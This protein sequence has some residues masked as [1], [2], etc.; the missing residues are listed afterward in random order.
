MCV[1][2]TGIVGLDAQV[3]RYSHPGFPFDFTLPII[4]FCYL[5]LNLCLIY[6]PG[7]V[8]DMLS[9]L[10]ATSPLT[11]TSPSSSHLHSA[12]TA[13]SRNLAPP[14]QLLL[15]YEYPPPVPNLEL[16]SA[17]AEGNV[18]L[19]HYALTHGQPV[20][21]VL[22]GV[23]P[24]HAAAAGGSISAVKMLIDRGADVNAPRLPRRYS[25]EKKKGVP[26]L[27]A[28]GE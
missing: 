23:Q 21:S 13:L 15:F 24:I 5:V 19:V 4:L 28:A 26:S 27:G 18:G 3:L 11:P 20:N 16:H 17:A 9:P 1:E 7:S 2:E 12:P 6:L 10:R 8:A 22:H 14:P 25:N